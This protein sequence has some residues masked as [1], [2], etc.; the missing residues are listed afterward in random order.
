M[1]QPEF[2]DTVNKPGFLFCGTPT[3]ELVYFHPDGDRMDKKDVRVRIGLKE[4]ADP[5]PLCYCFGFTERMVQE[6]VDAMGVCTIPDRIGAEVRKENCA[7]EVRN[8]QGSC[9]LGNV[10]AVVKRVLASARTD[11]VLQRPRA[12]NHR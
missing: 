12:A 7:C 9:C 8:P 3:C 11:G 2:L 4:T 1:V 5:V 6:E 10:A